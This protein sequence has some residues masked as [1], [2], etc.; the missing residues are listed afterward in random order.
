MLCDP[1]RL[2][3][4]DVVRKLIGHLVDGLVPSADVVHQLLGLGGLAGGY[5]AVE[6]VEVLLDLRHGEYR[7]RVAQVQAVVGEE[8]GEDVPVGL[9]GLQGR[10]E[11]I[12][13]ETGE[14]LMA[15]H[16]GLPGD[17]HGVLL[18]QVAEVREFLL[19]VHHQVPL[20]G[21]DGPAEAHAFGEEHE[22]AVPLLPLEAVDAVHVDP[23]GH[24]VFGDLGLLVQLGQLLIGLIEAVALLVILLHVIVVELGD[25]L[26]VLL[27]L[28]PLLQGCG[29]VDLD[30]DLVRLYPHPLHDLVIEDGDAPLG[31]VSCNAKACQHEEAH[32]AQGNDH[33]LVH[34]DTTSRP[35]YRGFERMLGNSLRCASAPSS[36]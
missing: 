7:A 27:G 20:V 22:D 11:G 8:L 25:F 26:L 32:D 1:L 4:A 2:H 31:T 9:V 14:H 35:L 24:V 10:A 19:E 6:A 16:D 21:I 23:S 17:P 30:P 33:L 36:P 15:V 29:I 18:E 28:D 34:G 5:L 13:V 12:L 3:V